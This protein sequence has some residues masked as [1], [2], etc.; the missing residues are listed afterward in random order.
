MMRAQDVIDLAT[1]YE[2]KDMTGAD[3]VV[4]LIDTYCVETSDLIQQLYGALADGDAATFGRLAHSIKSSSNSLGA[5]VFGQQARELEMLGKATDLAS[6]GRKVER[7]EA[8]F[9]QVRDCLEALR[10]EP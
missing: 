6:V 7:L 10:D 4:D 8:D 5:L 2:L 9:L 1:F 3:F